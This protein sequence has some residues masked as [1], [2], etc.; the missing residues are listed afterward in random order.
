MSHFIAYMGLGLLPMLLRPGWRPV[1][2]LFVAASIFRR[3]DGVDSDLCAGALR[4]CQ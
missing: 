4:Y 2:V 1:L 3:S